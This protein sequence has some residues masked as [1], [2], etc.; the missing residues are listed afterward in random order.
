MSDQ[1]HKIQ[2]SI[3]A[4]LLTIKTARFSELNI[5]KIPT[6]SFTFHVSSLM[7]RGYVQKVNGLYL[8]STR[9]KEFASRFDLKAKEIPTQGKIS[10]CITA[11]KEE[12]GTKYFLLTGRLK[13]PFAGKV[14][15]IGGTVL[16]GKTIFRAAEEIFH[17]IAGC[18]ASFRLLGVQHKM[19]YDSAGNLLEDRFFYVLEAQDIEGKISIGTE[20]T[21]NMWATKEEIG[22]LSIFENVPEV[23][24]W[25]EKDHFSFSEKQYKEVEL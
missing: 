14:G 11:Q 15:F 5:T 21:Q 18:K 24:L 22:Q 20:N 19:D 2:A 1:P 6:D 16:S 10:V 7:N 9:G 12:N 8:L 3:L 13:N 25:L 23:L 17:E 4:R